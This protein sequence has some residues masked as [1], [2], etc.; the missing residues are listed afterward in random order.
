M[1]VSLQIAGKYEKR[2]KWNDQTVARYDNQIPI[3]DFPNTPQEDSKYK[4]LRS[5]DSDC[6]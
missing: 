4:G 5:L 2:C 1:F 3:S 6:V